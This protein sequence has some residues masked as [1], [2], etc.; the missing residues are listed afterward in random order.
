MRQPSLERAAEALAVALVL[1]AVVA[2]AVALNPLL[3]VW[4]AGVGLVHSVVLAL[5]AFLILRRLRWVNIGTS[6]VTGLVVGAVPAAIAFAGIPG[7]FVPFACFGAASGFLFGAWLW[8]RA[9][10]G[11]NPSVER[12]A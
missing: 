5:P 7:Q 12:T 3:G 4:V 6:T 1:P 11:S 10:K 2:A 9:R 8:L